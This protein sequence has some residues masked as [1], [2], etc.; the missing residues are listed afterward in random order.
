MRPPPLP[1]GSEPVRPTW[2][3]H[4]PPP[5]VVR[6]T[7]PIKGAVVRQGTLLVIKFSDYHKP[8][9]DAVKAIPGWRYNKAEQHWTVHV[10]H[11]RMVRAAAERHGWHLSEQVQAL[12]DMAPGDLPLLVTAEGEQLILDGP[13]R[14][15]VWKILHDGEARLADDGRWF[16]PFESAV[17]TILDLRKIAK[18][19]FTG[20]PTDLTR[21]IDDAHQMLLLSRAL[22][23]SP[24]WELTPRFQRKLHDFQHPGVEYLWRSRRCFGWA[25]MGAGKT[26]VAL[27]AVE[28]ADF[29]DEASP[30]PL[31]VICPP[32]LKT[33]WQR[34]I[35]A[36]VPH[37][38]S[39][40]CSGV[41][42]KLPVWQPDIWICNYDILG[43]VVNARG[44][45]TPSWV[46][47]WL[48][49]IAAG[50]LRSMIVD[51]GH[52]CGNEKTKR[53]VAVNQISAALP[54]EAIRYELTATPVRNN[55]IELIP[56]LGVI[57]RGGEFGD[58]NKLRK[59]DR[60]PRRLRTV[61]AWR[62]TP[63]EVLKAIGALAE[64]ESDQPIWQPTIVD[65]DPKVMADYRRAEDDFI[66]FVQAKAREKA[67]ELGED[68]D[69]AAVAAALRAMPALQ[70]Q[71]VNTLAR[72]AGQAKI[73]AAREWVADFETSGEKL[74]VFAENLDMMDA[75]AGDKIPQIRGGVSNDKRMKLCDRFQEEAGVAPDDYLQTLVLQIN[76]A[77]EGL[78]LTKAY[79]A[80]FAQL[81]WVPGAMD[82]AAGRA[83][84]RMNDPHNVIC[85][86]LICAD[87]IDEIR[88]DV[89][90]RKRE[91]VRFVT[92]GDRIETLGGSTAGEVLARYISRATGW[93]AE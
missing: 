34:E 53:T 1:F 22:E 59:D 58:K 26:T 30:Y 76:A 37:R 5:T 13:Y 8:F 10:G 63:S 28:H 61:C 79:Q 50:G 62:P 86:L 20:S 3:Q 89:L 80:L 41:N 36:C 72:L 42:P 44:I 66:A 31:L 52:R 74:L 55:R 90:A 14:R 56:Q 54:R 77:G 33:N 6:R 68:P 65:G 18:V 91:E 71:L 9:T 32:G 19:R 60:L 39:W 70:L 84:W 47:L 27:A 35:A 21:R 83:A 46:N 7:R 78:T 57:G 43:Q 85:H 24:G 40:I 16:V 81:D 23:P 69:S 51:E 25:T 87:T 67:I 82:Q 12:P 4:N 73:S 38:T 75:I 11:V 64:G 48:D 49:K 93:K 15:D 2:R 29:T 17:D 92:D 88:L 45:K